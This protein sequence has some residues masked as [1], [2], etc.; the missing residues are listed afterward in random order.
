LTRPP[1]RAV[2]R[3][4]RD[5]VENALEIARLGRLGPEGGQPYVVADEDRIH[6]LRHY[7]EAR[8]G[9]PVLLV[10][11]LMLTAECYDVAPDLSAVGALGAAGLDTWVIDFGAPEHEEGGMERTLDDHV[12]ACARAIVTVRERTGRDV[13]VAGYSQGGMFAYQA[14]AWLEG[15]GVASLVTFGS[16][17][18]IHKSLPNVASDVA[19]RL[20]RGARPLVAP[21]LRR[22]RGLPG[23]LSSTGFK[24]LTPHK[25]VQQLFDFV[26]KL[27][28]R[29][30]LVK[31]ES[32]RRFLAGEG[33][34]AWPGP[35]L[36]R[37]FDDFIVHNR[38]LTGGLVIDGDTVTLADLRC[39]ILAFYGRRDT[40]ARPAAVRAITDAA[41]RAEHHHVPLPA[42]HFGLV[43]GTTAMR[44][45]WPAVIDWVRWREQGGAMPPSIGTP[46]PEREDD[47]EPEEAFEV[48]I[49]ELLGSELGDS[50]R[51]G[52]ERLGDAYRDAS[53][54]AH[55]LYWQLP[56][57]WRLESLRGDTRVSASRTLAEQARRQPERTFFLWKGRAFTYGDADARVGAVARGLLALGVRPGDRV[58]VLMDPRPSHL[59][60]V[61]ALN[62]VGAVAVLYAGGLDD[63]ALAEALRLEPLRALATD[64]TNAARGRRL[65]GG[66][67]LVLGGARERRDLPEGAVD[68]EAID[69]E[70][71]PLPDWYVDDGGRARELAMVLV[72][73]GPG[74]RPKLSRI[75][76]G[77]WAFSAFGVA[78][79]ATLTP[80][81]TVYCC[82]PLQHPA[83]IMVAVGGAL[84]GGSRL[85]LSPGFDPER[86]WHD[87]R[88]YGATVAFYAGDMLRPLLRAPHDRGDRKHPL[89][90]VTGS[91]M[92]A[93]LWRRLTQRFGFGVLE[94]YASTERNLVLANASGEKVGA[95]GRALP[96]SV[97][98]QLARYDFDADRLIEKHGRWLRCDANEAGLAVV[99]VDERVAAAGVR[100]DAFEPGDRWL[101]TGDVLRRDADGDYWFVDRIAA[102]VR[103]HAGLVATTRVEDVLL[104][105]P[106]VRAAA[107]YGAPTDDGRAEVVVAALEN[108]GPLDADALSA[109]CRRELGAHERPQVLR[110]LERLPLTEG[111]RVLKAALRAEGREA[112]RDLEC[113]VWNEARG[114]YQGS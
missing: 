4:L 42:G 94:F 101:P 28:D 23:A 72:R 31:R 105:D 46:A 79:A 7:G 57:L 33:F 19:A 98:L 92:S 77:R 84:V 85:A 41:P 62:R 27:H 43:V 89:R 32:R 87:V 48:E 30:A 52:W 51:A 20:V 90:L 104:R 54:A 97:E 35:A 63:E 114:R 44:Q 36:V 109:L 53:D 88:R 12:R 10:P 58:G 113:L 107:V 1:W 69:P 5:S 81:D 9:P 11:P 68:M 8:G 60:L 34:V 83:G 64:P 108:D 70:A 24:L 6:K 2:R 25:E 18:D 13:H 26:R 47:L 106:A 71:T 15:E 100:K 50:L 16:P 78:S 103:T 14:A 37:F 29:Q 49:D 111:H 56:R 67:L 102:M 65:F 74:D 73:L 22:L 38:L 17:V 112:P 39:P 110:R 95:L 59:S 66:Q 91:G 82:L 3:R 21:T 86:F 96:G 99:R 75:S 40:F 76:N 93:D 45:T 80:D 61:T 55:D